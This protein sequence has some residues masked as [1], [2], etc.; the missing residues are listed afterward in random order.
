MDYANQYRESICNLININNQLIAS[1]KDPFI[2]WDKESFELIELNINYVLSFLETEYII[3][4]EYNDFKDFANYIYKIF[5]EESIYKF[6]LLLV[7][8]LLLSKLRLV[9]YKLNMLKKYNIE[10]FTK[11]NKD[12]INEF[13]EE[14]TL[15]I[16]EFDL[17]KLEFS[18][19]ERYQLLNDYS[20]AVKDYYTNNSSN[21]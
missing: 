4:D 3:D 10:S 17:F 9:D 16:G 8:E 1:S 18:N 12:G 5:K 15:Y 11:L 2:L 7:D 14:Y 13:I 6:L 20:K 19:V 21:K